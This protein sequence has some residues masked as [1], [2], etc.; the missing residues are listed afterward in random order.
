[1]EGWMDERKD[2]WKDG[3]TND[4]MDERKD[5]QNEG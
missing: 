2:E 4:K 1:M 3:E 5:G